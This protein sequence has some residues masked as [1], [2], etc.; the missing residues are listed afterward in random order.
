MKSDPVAEIIRLKGG[1][2]PDIFKVSR[3]MKN[4]C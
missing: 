2:V 3:L 1:E 4:C